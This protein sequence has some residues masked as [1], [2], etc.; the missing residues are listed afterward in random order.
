MT[1]SPQFEDDTTQAY[2]AGTK[3][4]LAYS[5]GE[6]YMRVENLFNRREKAKKLTT[7]SVLS[8][9]LARELLPLVKLIL[10]KAD[11]HGS[12]DKPTKRNLMKFIESGESDV[13][14]VAT[15]LRH[16]HVHGALTGRSL[17]GASDAEGGNYVRVVDSLA[18]LLLD[19]C[20]EKFSSM[21]R[22][23]AAQLHAN[24]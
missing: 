1:F 10:D 20:D 5:A 11:T 13:R 6:A 3:L 23:M 14:P 17:T 8:P 12:L 24:E 18:Q 16:V 21:V 19:K 22:L 7:W 4:L 2:R 15:A 9:G